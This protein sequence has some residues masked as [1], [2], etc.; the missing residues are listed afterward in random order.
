MCDNARLRQTLFRMSLP[1]EV[2]QVEGRGWKG[3]AWV[4]ASFQFQRRLWFIGQSCPLAL[5]KHATLI[6]CLKGG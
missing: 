2:G 3:S 6:E 4:F 1:T 5:M